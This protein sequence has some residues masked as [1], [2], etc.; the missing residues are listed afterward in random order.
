MTGVC[1][2]KTEGCLEM[3]GELG[4]P[5]PSQHRGAGQDP[6]GL[7]NCPSTDL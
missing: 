5:P 1:E 3:M 4:E 6:Q 7:S 2:L